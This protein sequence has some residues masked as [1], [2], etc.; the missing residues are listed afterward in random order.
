VVQGPGKRSK[1][2]TFHRQHAT[3]RLKVGNCLFGD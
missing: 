2:I 1:G 3:R